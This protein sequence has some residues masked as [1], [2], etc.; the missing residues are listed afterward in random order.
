MSYLTLFVFVCVSFLGCFVLFVSVLCVVCLRPMCCLFLS[1][2]LFVSVLCVVCLCPM[3]CLS[4][5]Y[6][7]FVS[8]LCVVCL[9]PMCCLSLSYVLCTKCFQFLRF[10][11]S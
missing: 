6:V 11:H 9:C 7:L 3:C 2:V 10:A 1:Y 8:V 4:P 5:S